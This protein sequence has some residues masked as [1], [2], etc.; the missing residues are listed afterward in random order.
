MPIRASIA[1][2]SADDEAMLGRYLLPGPPAV[3]SCGRDDSYAVNTSSPIRL[4]CVM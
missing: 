4:C 1:K 3:S 2:S